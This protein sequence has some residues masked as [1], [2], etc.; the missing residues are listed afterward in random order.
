MFS[1]SSQSLCLLMEALALEGRLFRLVCL[2]ELGRVILLRLR[3]V[4]AQIPLSFSVSLFV[5]LKR[6]YSRLFIFASI[7]ISFF[8]KK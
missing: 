8:I 5:S 2:V 6:Q 1:L 7:F 4:V 3:L